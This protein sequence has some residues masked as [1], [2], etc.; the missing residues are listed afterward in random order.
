[1]VIIIIISRISSNIHKSRLCFAQSVRELKSKA[2]RSELVASNNKKEQ[3]SGP[4]RPCGGWGN[5]CHVVITVL[6]IRMQCSRRSLYMTVEG[7]STRPIVF[8]MTCFVPSVCMISANSN[9]FRM[10]DI[11]NT[12]AGKCK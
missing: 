1:M 9:N 8:S 10:S 12:W 7:Q 2:C 4:C 5:A 6:L 11:S 3:S